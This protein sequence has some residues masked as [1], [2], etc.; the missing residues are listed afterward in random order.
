MHARFVV[1]VLVLLASMSTPTLLRAQ[2]TI[3][4]WG[5]EATTGG[6]TT[7]GGLLRFNNRSFAWIFQTLAFYDRIDGGPTDGDDIFSVDARV[8][9]RFYRRADTATRPFTTISAL[10]EHRAS[11]SSRSTRPGVALELG[12]SHFFSRH[13]SLG[14]STDLRVL[15]SRERFDFPLPPGNGT[16][17]TRLSI[18]FGGFRLVGGVYF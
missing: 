11:G 1:P 17:R 9:L 16:D 4:R 15:Y 2:D 14:V 10:L 7:G 13:L 18:Y 8:G 5:A 3:P 6:G 12:V